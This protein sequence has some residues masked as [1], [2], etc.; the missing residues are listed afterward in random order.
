M[1]EEIKKGYQ[2]VRL[3]R[4][5]I[6]L[7]NFLGGLFWGLGTVTGGVVII[8]LIGYLLTIL[9]AIPLIGD[10]IAKIIREVQYYS[11]HPIKGLY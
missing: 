10:F 4:R 6:I 1:E 9:G 3:P 2:K 5:E 7:N 8:G 11:S